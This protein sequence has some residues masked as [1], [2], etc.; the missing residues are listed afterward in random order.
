MAKPKKKIEDHRSD[1]AFAMSHAPSIDQPGSILNTIPI[2]CFAA[3][4]ILIV[5]MSTYTRPMSQF[6]WTKAFDTEQL[7]DFFSYN[8]MVL[9]VIAGILALLMILFRTTTQALAIK[10]CYAYIPMAVYSVFVILSYIFSNYKEFALWGWNDRFEG[11]IPLLCY[12]LMLFMVINSIN[13]EENIRQVVYPIAASSFLLSLL[14]LSQALDKDFFR[15]ELGQKLLVPNMA[16]ANGGTTWD[17]IEQATAN[18]DLYLRFTFND[19]Q[20]Y[21]TVYNINYV[22]FYLT[23][24]VPLFTMLFIRLMRDTEAP[25]W[26]KIT[27]GVL[28]ALLIF[29]LI[30]SASS[31]GYLGLGVAFI[32]AVVVFNKQLLKW[33][34]PLLVVIVIIAIVMVATVGRWWPEISGAVKSV[35][36]I[37]NET[38][39][40]ELTDEK[41]DSNPVTEAGSAA[42]VIDYMITNGNTVTMSINGNELIAALDIEGDTI[43]GMQISD[44]DGNV[45][46]L[47]APADNPV[48]TINDSRFHDYATV[49][50]AYDGSRYYLQITTA[51]Y[52]WNFTA[53]NGEVYYYSGICASLA[54]DGVSKEDIDSKLVKLDKVETWGFKN[55]PDFGSGRGGIWS[56]SFPLLKHTIFIGYGADTYCAVY[57]QNDYAWKWS[58]YSGDYSDYEAV[59]A[60]QYLIV[61]KPHNM[62]LHMGIGTGCISLLAMIALYGIYLI[63]SVKLFWKRDMENDFLLFAGAGTFLGC[64]G[65]MVTGLVDDSTVSVMP[66]FYTMLGMGIAINMI[67]KRRDDKALA[68]AK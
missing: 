63:Q 11:T 40:E 35:L 37:Q 29:N 23:L 38:A 50:L 24:L 14:G 10:R 61:D 60:A 1:Y 27:V 30:G 2:A 46:E 47:A 55:N 3:L 20:I 17:A 9:I 25:L 45:L 12:M 13:T 51:G 42:P 44:A 67:I 33:I 21:Q 5:R 66:L 31:G 39:V 15:T 34:K 54:S 64:T 62:Y 6:F 7:S 36:G 43:I 59:T 52:P 28:N 49:A 57:P 16:L 56:H 41:A 18:G 53:L 8:K 48:Y 65:F 32:L 19:R 26:K 22:A 4:V 58:T 68:A